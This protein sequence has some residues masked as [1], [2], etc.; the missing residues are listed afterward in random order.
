M[1]SDQSQNTATVTSTV[2]PPLKVVFE[3]ADRK[4][5]LEETE[6]GLASGWG[7]D[8]GAGK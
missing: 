2:V 4:A 3:E 5:I 7:G 1:A 6:K 8:G